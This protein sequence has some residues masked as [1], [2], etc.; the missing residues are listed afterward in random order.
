MRGAL[1]GVACS[2]FVIVLTSVSGCSSTER[3]EDA[4][5]DEAD[6][7]D[8]PKRKSRAKPSSSSS[9]EG[10]GA[11]AGI[12]A[13]VAPVR[14]PASSCKA[15][16][17]GKKHEVLA[18]RRE[19]TSMLALE[20]GTLF[21]AT[22]NPR[23]LKGELV[24]I[25]VDG[26]EP[27]LL[28][29]L[30]EGKAEVDGLAVD[31]SHAYFTQSGVL[32]RVA[33]TGGAMEKIADDFGKGVVAA[34]GFVYGHG[35]DKPRNF[36]VL[37]RVSTTGTPPEVIYER[38]RRDL[39]E[40]AALGGFAAVASDGVHAY[41][42]DAGKR[43]VLAIELSSREIRTLGT[44]VAYPTRLAL[45]P[46]EPPTPKTDYERRFPHVFS[47]KGGSHLRVVTDPTGGLSRASVEG[48]F[49]AYASDNYMSP[50]SIV[51]VAPVGE[52]P[53]VEVARIPS[54]VAD[55]TGDRDCVYV[56]RAELEQSVLIALA[57]PKAKP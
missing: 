35:Y 51:D 37:R 29:D 53:T 52:G 56:S 43:T 36:D 54:D 39:Q 34:G 6:S 25:D 28:A 47:L 21:V 38:E 19:R 3:S 1:L 44:G 24:A 27:R 48:R 5:T 32:R 55:L 10:A 26:S 31:A 18:T 40:V 13:P 20:H 11:S 14:A 42:A 8:R 7:R 57:I 17:T 22:W 30:T 41:L 9:A 16:T 50:V 49:S 23:S 46:G 33:R 2:W 12:V 4:A 45:L 15:V